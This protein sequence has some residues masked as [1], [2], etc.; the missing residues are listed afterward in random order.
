MTDTIK[1]PSYTTPRDSAARDL[2][3][4][5]QDRPAPHRTR[6]TAGSRST[7]NP[8]VRGSSPWRRTPSDLAFHRFWWGARVVSTKIISSESV[9]PLLILLRSGAPEGLRIAGWD[10][11]DRPGR[12]RIPPSGQGP[13]REVGKNRRGLDDLDQPRSAGTSRPATARPA[14]GPHSVPV[15]GLPSRQKVR[16][17]RCPVARRAFGA[18][19]II[20]S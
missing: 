3:I 2:R 6:S 5:A 16:A 20:A 18:T 12:E 15:V 8:R 19:D 10:V 1:G 14:P 4:H 17:D 7:L 13:G 11:L 9:Q